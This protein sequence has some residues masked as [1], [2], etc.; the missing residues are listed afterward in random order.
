MNIHINIMSMAFMGAALYA[1]GITKYINVKERNM[2]LKSG[3]EYLVISS[4]RLNTWQVS[5]LYPSG[6]SSRKTC[7]NPIVKMAT[8]RIPPKYIKPFTFWFNTDAISKKHVMNR[9]VNDIK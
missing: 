7:L 9:G 4:G 6:G 3:A 1:I 2:L 5:G 8:I